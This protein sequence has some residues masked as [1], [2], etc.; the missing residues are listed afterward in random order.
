MVPLTVALVRRTTKAL[1]CKLADQ[2]Q[3]ILVVYHAS[4]ILV[5]VSTM[6]EMASG[7][8]LAG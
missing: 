4:T 2:V 3:A 7:M 8:R 6:L 5:F 1:G